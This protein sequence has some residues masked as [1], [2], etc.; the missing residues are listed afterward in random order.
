MKPN[1][2]TSS[3]DAN[4]PI[5]RNI[6]AVTIA[7]G[8]IGGRHH[9]LDEWTDVERTSSVKGTQLILAT[10]VSLATN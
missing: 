4:I 6:P 8:G 5:S 3:T 7:H 1:Y 10:I 2:V 9:A